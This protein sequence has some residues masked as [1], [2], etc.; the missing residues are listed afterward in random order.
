MDFGEKELLPE[1]PWYLSNFSLT[2]KKLKVSDNN[3]RRKV[4]RVLVALLS[5][6]RLN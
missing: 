6:L 4:K 2:L 1:M 3:S 5:R